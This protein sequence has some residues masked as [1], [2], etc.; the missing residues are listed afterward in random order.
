MERK[1]E[2]ER[3]GAHSIFFL[4]KKA[5]VSIA[6]SF[7]LWTHHAHNILPPDNNLGE[8]RVCGSGRGGEEERG[9]KVMDQAYSSVSFSLGEEASAS[10]TASFLF[11]LEKAGW[12]RHSCRH[13]EVNMFSLY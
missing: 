1:G 10:I 6:V 7:S 3:D 4:K 11:L 9:E 8:S 13:D 12:I 5:S 2:K